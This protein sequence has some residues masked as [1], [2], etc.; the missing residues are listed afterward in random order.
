MNRVSREAMVAKESARDGAAANA[1][2]K[3]A[4][5][6]FMVEDSSMLRAR[7]TEV[8][9][10]RDNV[11]IVGYAETEETAADFLATQSWDV[12]I[13]DLQLLH[14]TGLGVLRA[15]A[16]DRRPGTAVI[17]LTNYSISAYRV[18]C[19][20]L[21]ADYFLDKAQEMARVPEVLAEIME[22]N[23]DGPG[24]GTSLH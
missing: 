9:A 11:E 14:G 7:L 15:I 21:G 18:H 10:H 12:L 5:R 16:K 1:M 20:R 6:I 3:Q 2:S 17:V 8:L 13:L 19:A 4:L 22:K 23:A 24:G